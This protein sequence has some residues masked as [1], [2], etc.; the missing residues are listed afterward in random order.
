MSNFTVEP[1]SDLPIFEFKEDISKSVRKHPCTVVVGETGSGKSTQ[2]PQYLLS[3]LKTGSLARIAVTQPRRVAAISV[4][5]RVASE[6][7]CK[8]GMEVGYSIRFDDK[9][10]PRTRI[11]F[12]TDGVLLRE[13]MSDPDLKEYDIIVL[14]EAH[15]R[16]L[17]TDILMGLL[18]QLQ[19]RRPSLR[20]VVMSATLHVELYMNFFKVYPVF[21]GTLFLDCILCA[22]VLMIHQTGCQSDTNSWSS[23]PSGCILHHDSN[24]GLRGRCDA[25]VLPGALLSPWTTPLD[26]PLGPSPLTSNHHM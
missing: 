25:H 19:E 14:D 13:C 17:Q 16:S 21:V 1:S 24:S 11:K 7:K 5:Q 15:E 18:R 9:T 12:V 6:R 23:I 4:A 8:V 22:H 10:S 26:H 3:N 20:L 2:L